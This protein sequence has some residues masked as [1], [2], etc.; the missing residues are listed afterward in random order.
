MINL[1]VEKAFNEQIKKEL[2]SAYLYLAMAGYFDSMNLDGMAHW[3]KVQAKEEFEH[4]MKFYNH[5][6]ERG[7]KV[8]FYPLQLLSR[9]WNSPLDVFEHVYEHE[10][11]VTESINNLVELAKAENDYPAQVLLQWFVNE[12]VEEEANALK[13]VETLKKVKDSPIGIIM[14]DRE[15]ARRE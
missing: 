6:I 4:A 8:E 14:L 1:K 13:I 2:E 12:Q 15:L 5:I 9:N 11:K 10:Q 3:M 7:G